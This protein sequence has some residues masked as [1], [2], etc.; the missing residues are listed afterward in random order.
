MGRADGMY[1]ECARKA[2]ATANADALQ[3]NTMLANQGNLELL[4]FLR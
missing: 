4:L 2:V 1:K 3:S